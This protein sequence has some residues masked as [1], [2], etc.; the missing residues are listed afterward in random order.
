M[1]E[2]QR[3]GIWDEE[4]LEEEVSF[5]MYINKTFI[6]NSEHIGLMNFDSNISLFI[7]NKDNWDYIWKW[8]ESVVLNSFL[9]SLIRR[10]L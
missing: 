10:N 2:G 6:N 1:R 9:F 3:G 7:R 8:S 5:G 4:L